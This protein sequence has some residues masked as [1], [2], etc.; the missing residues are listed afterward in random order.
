MDSV[1]DEEFS[2]QLKEVDSALG[3]LRGCR[4]QMHDGTLTPLEAESRLKK[5]R[6]KLQAFELEVRPQPCDTAQQTSCLW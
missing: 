5:F 4:K 3:K 6:K 2:A 1:D